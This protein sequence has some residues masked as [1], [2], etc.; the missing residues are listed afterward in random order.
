MPS[1]MRTVHSRLRQS[2]YVG[3]NRCL[4]CTVLNLLIA[5]ALAGVLALVALPLG[6]VGLVASLAA[7]YFRG[8]LIPGTPTLTQQYLPDRVLAWFGKQP[9]AA[10][11]AGTM[12]FTDTPSRVADEA[13]DPAQRLVAAG[14]VTP[15]SDSDDLCLAPKFRETWWRRIEQFRERETARDQLAATIRVDPEALSFDEE[16]GTGFTVSYEG[17][18]IAHW[19]SK[20]AF[21]ADLAAD[22]TLG[23]WL[24][25]WDELPDSTRTEL[26]VRLR[27]LLQRCPACNRELDENVDMMSSC[28]GPDVRTVSLDC[29]QCGSLFSGTDR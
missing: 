4:P 27:A 28:C 18:R 12:Q 7:I 1:W 26:L 14:V 17:D 16:S 20:G 22:P 9:T 10:D 2:E 24:R 25:G 5:G 6:V 21:F 13:D 15:C 19:S 23:E 29:P 3:P 11:G 8:Y